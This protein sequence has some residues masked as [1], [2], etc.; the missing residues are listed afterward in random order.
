MIGEQTAVD[1][2]NL[3]KKT[4]PSTMGRLGG[5]GTGLVLASGG[6]FAVEPWLASSCPSPPSPRSATHPN[7]HGFEQPAPAVVN[8][9]K[10]SNGASSPRWQRS[11]GP[12]EHKGTSDEE[13]PQSVTRFTFQGSAP[14]GGLEVPARFGLS[15]RYQ[16]EA[17]VSELLGAKQVLVER[18]TPYVAE[19]GPL[20]LAPTVRRGHF[21]GKRKLPPKAQAP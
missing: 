15:P 17:G 20:G 7:Q 9:F 5:G 16:K 2:T 4:A 1:R 18:D 10:L 12:Y 19:R 21:A 14:T 8:K 11:L 3:L 13:T 6:R